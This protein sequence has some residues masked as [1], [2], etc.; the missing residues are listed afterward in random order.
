MK[1]III[2]V[3]LIICIFASTGYALTLTDDP[4]TMALISMGLT[5]VSKKQEMDYWETFWWITA[6]S[7]AKE[8]AD[9][10]AGRSFS[11][12]HIGINLAAMSFSYFVFEF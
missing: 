5:Q 8:V 12:S 2:V 10:A 4:G 7:V 3:L 11:F 6:F 1:K 9:V